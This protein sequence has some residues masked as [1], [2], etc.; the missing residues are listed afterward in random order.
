[1]TQIR[2][3]GL[4][5]VEEDRADAGVRTQV[6]FEIVWDDRRFDDIGVEAAGS[7]AQ[8]DDIPKRDALIGQALAP[9]FVRCIGGDVQD[10]V[11]DQPKAVTRMCVVLMCSQ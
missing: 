7:R 11:H 1:M 2:F 10:P 4:G 8:L 9:L 6:G 5:A 3:L